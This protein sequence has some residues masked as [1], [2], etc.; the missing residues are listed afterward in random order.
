MN[1]IELGF[2]EARKITK[3]FA[4]TF[5]LASLFL[6]KETRK[7]AYAVYAICR[8]SDEAVDS[9]N[10]KP[11]FEGVERI[12]KN[13]DSVYS[14]GVPADNLLLAFQKTVNKYNIPEEYFYDLLDGMRIDLT[15]TRYADFR[16]LDTYCYKVAGV[17]GLIML[18]IFGSLDQKAEKPAIDLGIAMQMT[19]IL[20]DIKED[21]SRGRIYIPA[22][23][24][25]KF[26]VSE[27]QISHHVL[28]ENFKSLSSYLINKTR[29]YYRD[30][31]AGI[32]LIN[33]R[34]SRLAVIAMQE[35][36]S[37]IL[38]AIE[39]NGY[40]VFSQRAFVGTLKKWGIILK[41]L[42]QGKYLCA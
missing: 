34:H 2:E 33:G 19:N 4:K 15:K 12:K 8:I 3:H 23:C 1:D 18:K 31:E 39:D 17:V 37:G 41:V 10:L 24:L 11:S 21:Y 29:Q 42:M 9:Q 40:D 14:A 22:E 35:M 38:G 28:S 20:R 6:P 36:Y 30:S 25:E 13:I 7:A 26:K 5:Y 27:V 32:N 16:E